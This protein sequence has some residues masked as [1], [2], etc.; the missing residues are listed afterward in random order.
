ME[1][2]LLDVAGLALEGS[3]TQATV[4]EHLA[5]DDTHR[6]SVSKAV[7][8]GGLAGARHTHQGRQG[9]GLDPSVDVVKN[10]AGL[11]LDLDLV[12]HVFPVEDAG[13]GLQNAALLIGDVAVSLLRS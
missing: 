1:I 11:A 6:S 2:L 9:T 7:E 5:G 10:L 12:A 3:V 4:D 13:A 8:K